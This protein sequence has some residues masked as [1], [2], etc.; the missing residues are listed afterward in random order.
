MS[1]KVFFSIFSFSGHCV[2]QKKQKE[3]N[4]FSNFGREV[5]KNVPVE[6]F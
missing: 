5:P 4:D 2:Q 3:Q 1:F 6:L